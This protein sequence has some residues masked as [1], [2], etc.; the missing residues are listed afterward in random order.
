M[1]AFLAGYALLLVGVGILIGVG[2]VHLAM[3]GTPR[4]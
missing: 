3:Q 4:E 1:E 2:L